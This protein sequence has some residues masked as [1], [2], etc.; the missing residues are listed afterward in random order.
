[1]LLHIT[2]AGMHMFKKYIEECGLMN[3]FRKIS[4]VYVLQVFAVILLLGYSFA[5]PDKNT[6]EPVTNGTRH[7]KLNTQ[8]LIVTKRDSILAGKTIELW[9]VNAA[10]NR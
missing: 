6:R 8:P 9:H 7:S 3:V 2:I 5:T 4:L 10:K 1:M